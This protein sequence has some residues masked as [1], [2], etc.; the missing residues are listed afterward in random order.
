MYDYVVVEYIIHQTPIR[1]ADS[2]IEVYKITR[3]FEENDI[4][5]SKS[6]TN[7]ILV[8]VFWVLLRFFSISFHNTHSTCS[9]SLGPSYIIF[10]MKL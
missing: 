10:S 7:Q 4:F 2:H 8:R 6:D 9:P 1:K 3:N 5:F